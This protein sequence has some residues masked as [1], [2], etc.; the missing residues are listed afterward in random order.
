MGLLGFLG[1][2]SGSDGD[3]DH[4]LSD[5]SDD[6]AGHAR[7]RRRAGGGAAGGGEGRELAEARRQLAAQAAELA[8]LQDRVSDLLEKVR[9]RPGG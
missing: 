1:V 3:S 8:E 5:G 6:F 4:G 7:G 9:G 2:S